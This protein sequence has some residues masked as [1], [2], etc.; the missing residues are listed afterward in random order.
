MKTTEPQI[1]PTVFGFLLI[2]NFTLISMS[3]AVE[4]LRMANRVAGSR[5][6]RWHMFSPGGGPV[7]ASDGLS[8]NAGFSI[9]DDVES[10]AAEAIIVCGGEGIER[11]CAKPVMRWLRGCGNRGLALGS[12]CTGGYLLGKAGLL[13]GYRCSIHWEQYAAMT[14][15][16]PKVDVSRSIFTIERDRFTS[17]GGTAPM[18]MMLYFVRRQLGA[19]TASDVADQFVHERIRDT[20]DLQHMPLRHVMGGQS[21]KLVAAVELM[22]SNIREPLSQLELASYINLSRRQLQRL[23][24]KYLLNSPS[25][26]YL[27]L[28]LA[29]ARQLLFQTN[30]SI[31]EIAAQTGFV[32][33]SHFSTTYKELYGNTPSADRIDR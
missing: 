12:I 17:S 26:Y 19:E 24:Q 8:I 2:D 31:V 25:H 5:V 9:R 21:A 15:E 30:L 14:V 27:Q 6:Y 11:Y 18:D 13:D 22:E 1:L 4:V 10:S 29:R 7:T 23:F 20:R 16:F 28:R 32:S 33:S 3:S